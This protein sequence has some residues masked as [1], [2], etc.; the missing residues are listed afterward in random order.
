MANDRAE[1]TLTLEQDR[2]LFTLA[3][4]ELGPDIRRLCGLI[5]LDAA[6]AADAEQNAWHQAW[7]KRH[8]LRDR[9]RFRPWMVRIAANEAKQLVRSGR[10][11]R[12][13]PLDSVADTSGPGDPHARAELRDV[14]ASMDAPDRELLAYRYVLGLTSDEMGPLLGITAEGVR[15]RLK[16]LRD[17]VRNEFTGHA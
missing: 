9:D 4:H 7:R 16:R 3:V 11:H 6:L 12:T 13:V 14:L 10:R 15:S 5:T 2:V 17:R 1:P 8:L